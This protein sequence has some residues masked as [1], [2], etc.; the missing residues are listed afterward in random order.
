MSYIRNR[1]VSPIVEVIVDKKYIS[2]KRS[3]ILDFKNYY[4]IM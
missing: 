1:E 3:I 2:G 4:Y